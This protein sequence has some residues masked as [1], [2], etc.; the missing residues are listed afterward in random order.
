M[1]VCGHAHLTLLMPE[2]QT[3]LRCRHCRLTIAEEEVAGG[4]CPECLEG[5]ERRAD[6][7]RIEVSTADTAR[8]RCEDC[9]LVT[10]AE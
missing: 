7:E 8:V 6:F 4:P 9:G 2:Q 1:D 5:G 10:T 3:R